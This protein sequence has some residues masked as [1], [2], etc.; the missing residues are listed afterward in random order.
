M[1]GHLACVLTYGIL[2]SSDASS[3]VVGASPVVGMLAPQA[4]PA[5][6]RGAATTLLLKVQA[7][8]ND[9]TDLKATFVQTYV[10]QIYGT[11]KVSEGQ[12]R[13]QRPGKMVWDYADEESADYWVDG[14]QLYVIERATKQIIKQNLKSSDIAGA[15]KFLFGGK[16]LTQ[17]FLVK[18]AGESLQKRYA[19]PGTTAIRL[20]PKRENKHYR[21]L[22]LVVEDETGRVAAFVVLNQDK[23]TNHFVL[24]D[25][26][27]NEGVKPEEVTFKRPAGYHEVDAQLD[28]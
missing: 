3:G 25:V 1:I 14:T 16:E 11:K 15:E 20:K 26:V 18:V 6:A 19:I 17:D 7:F 23:S 2:C 4:T 8:Y 28:E 9:T 5:P 21:E 24:T 12:L 27:R 22:M 10:N 13:A